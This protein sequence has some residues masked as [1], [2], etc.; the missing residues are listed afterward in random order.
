MPRVRKI[1]T[2]GA[3]FTK[4]IPDNVL[5][6]IRNYCEAKENK[7]YITKQ[8]ARADYD[9]LMKILKKNGGK[10]VR[11]ENAIV[12]DRDITELFADLQDSGEW[13]DNKKKYQ[14]FGTPAEVAKNI[15]E[16]WCNDPDNRYL[17][18]SAGRADIAKFMR[19]RVKNLDCIELEPE[20]RAYLKKEGYNVVAE[21]FLE[22]NPLIPYDTIV[23]NPPFSN[24][25]DIKHVMHAHE[26]AANVVAIISPGFQFKTDRL[27]TQ[28]NKLMEECGFVEDELAEGTF[29]ESGTNTK[30]FVVSLYNDHL[31]D[32]FPLWRPFVNLRNCVSRLRAANKRK[33]KHKQDAKN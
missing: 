6:I 16:N 19:E 24:N 15:V 11:K 9:S 14:F 22:F 1:S 27:H 4:K 31:D 25:Q 20:N 8:L 23:M 10:W 32:K 7:L 33:Y 26:M 17:E 28:F 12:F 13:T 3:N 29:K 18:P 30:T 2:L 21:D 5:E